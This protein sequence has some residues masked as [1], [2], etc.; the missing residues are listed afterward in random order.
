[1]SHQHTLNVSSPNLNLQIVTSVELTSTDGLVITRPNPVDLAKA[2]P[3]GSLSLGF[4]PHVLRKPD[5][6][7][8]TQ[9]ATRAAVN[10]RPVV[11]N[12]S[13]PPPVRHWVFYV[14]SDLEGRGSAK[15]KVFLSGATR[16]IRI[17]Q[18]LEVGHTSVSDLG[19]LL[20][21]LIL[22]QGVM[23]TPGT[24]PNQRVSAVGLRNA[25]ISN[26]LN[27][28]K[29]AADQVSG[30]VRM[31]KFLEFAL[32]ELARAERIG[33]PWKMVVSEPYGTW[34]AAPAPLVYEMDLLRNYVDANGNAMRSAWN[35]W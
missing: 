23:V 20:G 26:S 6:P 24:S 34:V 25:E 5:R 9:T 21:M 8:T 30:D 19:L 28:A 12:P 22:K 33:L 29:A 17:I 18:T 35:S 3:P 15:W 7:T 1:M 11:P 10:T 13:S 14:S 32:L 31:E 27:R 4:N 16:S 2:L